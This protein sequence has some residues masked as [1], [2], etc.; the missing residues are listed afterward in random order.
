MIA[1]TV[2]VIS[3]DHDRDFHSRRNY[4]E[5]PDNPGHPDRRKPPGYNKHH[6]KKHSDYHKHRGYRKRPY[7]K[8]RH[9]GTIYTKGIGMTI[10][11]IGA[12]GITGTDMQEN[13]RTYTN[14]G[15]ITA[16]VRI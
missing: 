11:V 13:T 8:H 3:K 1:T 12:P 15:D 2:P 4:R 10:T 6:Y 16:K 7:D 14:M 9:Y 5:R